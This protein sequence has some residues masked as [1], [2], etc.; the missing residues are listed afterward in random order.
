MRALLA[1]GTVLLTG[2]LA[3]RQAE[4]ATELTGC[5][6]MQ[7]TDFQAGENT[8][9]REPVAELTWY[10][11]CGQT[12]LCGEGPEVRCDRLVGTDPRRGGSRVVAYNCRGG[13]CLR[14]QRLFHAE[15]LT[16]EA[17]RARWEALN[18]SLEDWNGKKK[19]K[20]EACQKWSLSGMGGGGG[21]DLILTLVV[22]VPAAVIVGAGRAICEASADK[23]TT[24]ERKQI[25]GVE[26][27]IRTLRGSLK[28]VGG[29]PAAARPE[30][31][32]A[33]EP[34]RTSDDSSDDPHDDS[35]ADATDEAAPE[36][37]L[38]APPL[39]EAVVEP[40]T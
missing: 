10:Q 37:P 23:D 38:P 32:P 12:V 1:A 36:R 13:W 14:P 8:F 7:R 22:L 4:R 40:G 21:A 15:G 39:V 20:E 30:P 6:G 3:S 24:E 9:A 5:D 11:G 2:C 31:P 28:P 16:Y 19:E 26:Q 34:T 33:I 25:A 29:A 17:T 35:P 18:A 27:K